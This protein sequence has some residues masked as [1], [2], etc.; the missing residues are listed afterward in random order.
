M[1]CMCSWNVG[2]ARAVV[3]VLAVTPAIKVN[4]YHNL[5]MQRAWWKLV[6]QTPEEHHSVS[7]PCCSVRLAN[8]L[9]M[10]SSVEG[11]F[12]NEVVL[13]QFIGGTSHNESEEFTYELRWSK[14]AFHCLGCTIF[15]P[16]F[17]LVRDLG[18]VSETQEK[19]PTVADCLCETQV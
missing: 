16:S 17:L 19:T 6:G 12:Q 10:W 7:G 11:G 2:M 15:H 4:P 8:Y 14:W 9:L 13:E 3:G 5:Q 18:H 1:I